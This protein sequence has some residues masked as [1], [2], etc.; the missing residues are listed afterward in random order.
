MSAPHVTPH[1]PS[2]DS[3]RLDEPREVKM[4]RSKTSWDAVDCRP[5]LYDY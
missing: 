4:E 1:N 2:L 3:R 5:L